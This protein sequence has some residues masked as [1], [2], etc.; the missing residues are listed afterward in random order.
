MISFASYAGRHCRRSFCCSPLPNLA[1]RD[2]GRATSFAS[3]ATPALGALV[4]FS[5][6]VMPWY[7]IR[8]LPLAIIAH[9]RVWLYF[10]ALACA[11]FQ[12]MIDETERGWVLWLEYGLL[13]LLCAIELRHVG[14]SRA[15]KRLFS[16]ADYCSSREGC[17]HTLR[18]PDRK[19]ASGF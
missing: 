6:T 12:I 14:G 2:D 4:V 1:W 13:A 17:R 5:P 16:T 10:S 19:V 15:R 9:Q 7:I 8:A 3:Y 18:V 11:A